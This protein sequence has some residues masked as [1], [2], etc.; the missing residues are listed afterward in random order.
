MHKTRAFEYGMDVSFIDEVESE[1]GRYFEN[2]NEAD[3]LAI[4]KRSGANAARLRIWNEPAGSYCNLERTL[5]LGRR[6]KEQGMSFLLDFHYSDR[7][8]DPANQWKPKAWESLSFEDLADA[9]RSYTYSVLNALRAYGAAPDMVQIGNEVTPGMLWNDG[10]VDGEYDTDGQWEKFAALLKAGIDGAK[11]ALPDVAI[12]IHI[13]RGGD[14]AASVKFYD[15]LAMHGVAYD[16]IGLS[17]YS[18]WHGTLSDLE[19]NLADLAVRYGKPINVVETA[20]PWTLGKPEGMPV[21]VEKEEQL[22][23]GFPASPEGQA[24]YLRELIRI[25]KSVPNGLGAGFYWW[26]PAWIP[27]KME[28]SVGHPNNWSN[29]TLFDFQGNKMPGLDIL[30]EESSS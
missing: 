26:E 23:G 6:I 7:W 10:K 2:G 9:V 17:Y 13:D 24:A 11:A 22:H 8:A 3:V 15:R 28:W 14:N 30:G 4:M 20:Y 12:M 25:V 21:I 27:S 18:W 19:S 1:G 29:L 16:V 5:E